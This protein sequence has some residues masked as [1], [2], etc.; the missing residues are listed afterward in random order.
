MLVRIGAR[1]SA[2]AL[3][4]LL[5]WPGAVVAGPR[6]GVSVDASG[7]EA[8][9]EALAPDVAKELDALLEGEGLEPTSLRVRIFWLDAEEFKYAIHATFDPSLPADQI[10]IIET[11]SGC[12]KADVVK[13]TVAAVETKLIPPEKQRIAEAKPPP[14][15]VEDE[16]GDP[17]PPPPPSV[18]RD[19]ARRPLDKMGWAG[20]GLLVAGG[21]AAITGGALLGVGERRPEADMSQIRDFRPSGYVLLGTGGAMLVVGAIL[22]GIDR[23]RAKNGKRTAAHATSG[24][25]SR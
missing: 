7:L 22:L 21:A 19:P 15:V 12:A 24:R 8:V 5:A 9:G 17:P 10:P 2:I 18:D 3:A 23:A 14:P 25:V 11:C 4:T 20:V 6:G 13:K 1:V 16:G